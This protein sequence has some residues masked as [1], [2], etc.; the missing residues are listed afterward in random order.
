MQS[1]DV[2]HVLHT[3]RYA[4]RAAAMSRLLE[5]FGGVPATYQLGE[6]QY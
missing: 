6:T 3:E 5:K 2:L 4:E 1:D